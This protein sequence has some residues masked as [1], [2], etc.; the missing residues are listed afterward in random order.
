MLTNLFGADAESLI[1]L[2]IG[3][4]LVAFSRLSKQQYQRLQRHGVATQG[5]VLELRGSSLGDD[6]NRRALIR[7]VTEKDARW[8]TEETA[9]PGYPEGA[10][11]P[12]LYDPHDPTHFAVAAP[13]QTKPF[14][15]LTLAGVLLTG[16]AAW[17]I[18][19]PALAP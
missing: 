4:G 2:C 3:C 15:V 9:D 11:V 13:G 12:I 19:G 1:L 17:R 10:E 14:W 8:I 16:Y 5:V 6:D 18:V 7:F